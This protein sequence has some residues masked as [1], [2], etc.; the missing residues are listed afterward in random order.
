MVHVLFQAV[1]LLD[2][3]FNGKQ[4]L[5]TDTDLDNKEVD[6]LLTEASFKITD[7]QVMLAFQGNTLQYSRLVVLNILPGTF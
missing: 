6:A 5:S 4:T 3:R 7:L 1:A 2:Q